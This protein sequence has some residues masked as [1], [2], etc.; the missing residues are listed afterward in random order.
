MKEVIIFIVALGAILTLFYFVLRINQYKNFQKTMKVGDECSF[1][2]GEIKCNGTIREILDNNIYISSIYGRKK[3][4]R[5]E[6]Y[7]LSKYWLS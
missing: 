7:P 4:Q 6:V 3:R 5:S 2:Q 1:Y